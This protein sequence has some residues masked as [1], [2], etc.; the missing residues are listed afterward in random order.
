MYMHIYIYTHMY[1]SGE[2]ETLIAA[3]RVHGLRAS[4]NATVKYA[5]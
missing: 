2:P 5:I 1:I 3:K 4:V